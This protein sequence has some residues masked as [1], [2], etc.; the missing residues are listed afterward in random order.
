MS[1]AVPS[2]GRISRAAASFTE[3][4]IRE[5]N[6]LALEA[7]AVSL[8][9]GYP[10]FACPIELKE[11]ASQAIFA[12]VNQYAITWGAKPLRAA[13]AAKVARIHPDWIIDPESR[14]AYRYTSAG[15]EE[16]RTGELSVPETP[17]RVVMSELFAELDRA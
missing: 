6:R 12:D 7:G 17:I 14:V 5:M 1:Q 9:Q 10:D 11:A 3:S 8:A 16:V 13:I 15:L 2:A 4:V